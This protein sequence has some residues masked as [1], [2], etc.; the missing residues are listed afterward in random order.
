PTSGTSA[1]III[2]LTYPFGRLMAFLLPTKFRLLNPGLFSIK[3]HALS[4]IMIST[5]HTSYAIDTIVYR[6]YYADSYKVDFALAGVSIISS[7]FI[8]YSIAGMLDVH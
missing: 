3:Q 2:L 6:I 8:G 5:S 1:S 4:Y 7:Q